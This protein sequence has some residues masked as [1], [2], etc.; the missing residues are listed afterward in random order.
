MHIKQYM[1]K[2]KQN[3]WRGYRY[4]HG[5]LGTLASALRIVTVLSEGC[6]IRYR[7]LKRMPLAVR[8]Q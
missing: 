7:C 3:C 1:C 2:L 5:E 6:L 4:L 8:Y